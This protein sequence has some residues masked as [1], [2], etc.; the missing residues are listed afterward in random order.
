MRLIKT[1]YGYCLK[2][3][4]KGREISIAVEGEFSK[5][6]TTLVKSDIRVYELEEDITNV[7]A[8]DNRVLYCGEDLAKVI[9]KIDRL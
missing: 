5:D 2:I 8:K 4:Y 9:K 3:D 6:R 1:S 7:F